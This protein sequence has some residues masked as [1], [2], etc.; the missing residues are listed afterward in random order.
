MAVELI[1]RVTRGEDRRLSG[2]VRRGR[3]SEAHGFSGTLELMRV[4]ED[5]VPV[6]APAGDG[7]P[8]ARTTDSH[9]APAFPQSQQ[10]NSGEG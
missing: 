7:E 1:L 3:E 2:V 9:A 10:T 8:G 6:D 5:L 4:F